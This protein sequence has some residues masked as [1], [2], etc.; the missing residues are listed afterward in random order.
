MKC[1]SILDIK[2]DGSLKVRKRTLVITSCETSLNSKGK[3]KKEEQASF[4]YVTIYEVDDL[5]VE[6]ELAGAL[7][8]RVNKKGFHHGLTNDKFLK[9]QFL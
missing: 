7:E 4:D 2:I 8:K 3:F 9:H 1:I 5:K 6:V